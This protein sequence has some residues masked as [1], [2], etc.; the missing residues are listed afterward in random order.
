MTVSRQGLMAREWLWTLAA[1]GLLAAAFAATQPMMP[2]G[3]GHDGKIYLTI[4]GQ[5]QQGLPPEALNPFVLRIGTPWL[6]VTLAGVAGLSLPVA[7]LLVNLLASVLTAVLFAGWLRSHVA[8]AVTRLTLVVFFLVSPYSTFRFTFY[9]P[10][11]TDPVAALFLMM[12]LIVLDRL[13]HRIEAAS[14]M[15]LLLLVAVGC[16]FR[17]LV[18]VCAI[19]AMLVRPW[20]LL[21]IELAWRF[22]PIAGVLTIA[23]IRSW[24]IVTPSG[25]STATAVQ[26]WLEWKTLPMMVLAFLFVFGP[27][28]VLL[29]RRWRTTMREASERP[30]LAVFL[31]I[32]AAAAWLGA[33]D[34]ERI[35][36]FASPV[37]LM[38]IGK[39]LADLRLSGAHAAFAEVVVFQFLAYRVFVAIE[40]PAMRFFSDYYSFFSVWLDQL[41]RYMFL[42]AYAVLIVLTVVI[43]RAADAAS[44]ARVA[45]PTAPGRIH[46]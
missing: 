28:L 3:A 15:A 12:G 11:L 13:S 40:S 7:F 20:R 10:T 38:L 26:R 8:D 42:G 41:G 33:S 39:R 16:A 14:A 24:V 5:I 44:A 23:A 25:Y 46:V 4:A 34:T 19:A 21:P 32:F 27:L 1:I 43:V 18:L 35:L 29:L 6:V 9:Y 17:E 2:G 22:A 45:I 37:V 30:D 31:G 36:V